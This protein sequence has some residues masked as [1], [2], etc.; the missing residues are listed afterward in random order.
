[1]TTPFTLNDHR[2]TVH[3]TAVAIGKT[4]VLLRGPS[5]SGKTSLAFA[6]IDRVQLGDGFAAFVADDRVELYFDGGRLIARA[7]DAIA[8]L[9]ERYGRGIEHV[10]HVTAAEI[11]LV[12]DLVDVTDFKRMPQPE[13]LRTEI[14]GV[15][16]AR[17]PVPARRC[18][19]A[20][21]LVLAAL[22][23]FIG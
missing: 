10:E 7:P 12:I 5:G 19:E 6:L 11:R 9:A 4:G 14:E 8:G 16:M 17:Q 20:V 22:G 15:E 23:E 21:R 13:D 18:D 1:M 3:A 2:Q